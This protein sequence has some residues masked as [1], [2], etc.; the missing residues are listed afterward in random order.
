MMQAL[1]QCHMRCNTAP[2]FAK[3]ETGRSGHGFESLLLMGG[4]TRLRRYLCYEAILETPTSSSS[5]SPVKGRCDNSGPLTLRRQRPHVLS[6][7]RP[8]VSWCRRHHDI[9]E[10]EKSFRRTAEEQIYQRNTPLSIQTQQVFITSPF[11]LK[12]KRK[13]SGAEWSI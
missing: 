7:I 3:G 2:P 12:L 9:L 8:L 4:S 1:C 13:N 5:K 6:I 11:Q 10:V